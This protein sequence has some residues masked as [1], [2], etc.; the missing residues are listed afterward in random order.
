M[1][2]YACGNPRRL[3][4][5]AQA[6][7]ANAIEF[8]EVR[9]SDEP[10]EA[11]KQR[12]LLVHLVLPVPAGLTAS[13]IV[14]DGGERIPQVGVEWAVGADTLPAAD[15]AALLPG[16][17]HLDRVLVVRTEERG[18]F[19]RYRFALVR[20]GTDDPA[21]GFDPPLSH[22]SFS[23]KVECPND[24]DCAQPCTCAP[25]IHH[26][27]TIDYLAKDYQGFRRI[28]L[29]RMAV[30]SPDWTER[31]SAD[32]GITLIE[33][34]AYLADELSY[35]QDAVATEAYLNT[36][37]SRISLRRHARL[38]DYR[39]HDG[40]NARV[41][42]RIQLD[43]SQPSLPLAAGTPLLTRVA[44]LPPR[45]DPG[46]LDEQAARAAKPVVFET[47]EDAV[48][49]GDLGTLRFWTWGRLDASL[50]AGA[51]CA[52]LRGAHP[53]LRPGEVLMLVE[54]ASPRDREADPDPLRRWPVRL[55][56][57]T[58]AEDPAG[59][60][61]PDGV[62]DVTEIRWHPDDALPW[63]LCLAVDGVETAQAW[64]N[65]VLAD[66]G[67]AA[68]AVPL[69]VVPESHLARAET[70]CDTDPELIPVRFRP[71][72]PLQS[73]TRAVA[74]PRE[75]LL[76]VP[77]TPE[78]AGELAA[79]AVGDAFQA[80]FAALDVTVPDGTTI[81]GG[82]GLHAV[83]VGDAAWTIRSTGTGTL[84]LLAP[85]GPA[86]DAL[87][88][89]PRD[90]RP[91][92]TVHGVESDGTYPWTVLP[93][94]LGSSGDERAFVVEAEADGTAFLRFGDGEY[95]AAPQAG[96]RFSVEGRIGNG[97]QGNI[98]RE[99]LAHIVVAGQEILSV[100]NP[101]AASGGTDPETSD[102][103]RRD[104]PATLAVQE[105]AVTASDYEAMAL[106]TRSVARAAA[107]FRW[108]G[109]WHTVFVTA[110][111]AGGGPVDA[112]FETRLRGDL[113]RY[114]MAGS[115]LEVDA[116]RFVPLEIA[117]H[118]C[119]APGHRRAD[120]TAAARD[121]LSNRVLADGTLG[122]FHP[123][124]YTFGQSVQLSDLLVALH[125][126]TGVESV[127]TTKFQRQHEPGTTGLDDGLLPMGRLEVARLDNDPSFPEHGVL[128]LTCGGGL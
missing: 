66:H 41:W 63:S 37:R 70:T 19:S 9:H 28:M 45:I 17:T 42:A 114:R 65:V 23:F 43:P 18:D 127:D 110:D 14:V 38:V 125:A 105:R 4:A 49:H 1:A 97:R 126:I 52:T 116:P 36:A 101:L 34:L 11:L 61:F 6:G 85:P 68:A 77:R 72:L 120:V 3:L 12:T 25:D 29:E 39:V 27:P 98:G 111:R 50:P 31:S 40:C 74:A 2:R 73:V 87:V 13:W 121:V 10:D 93:D 48:L 30:L 86:V 99:T 58:V 67:A 26:P 94:L 91:V 124:R 81:L 109:S 44:D 21:P 107:T 100:S 46:S 51:T 35:R 108:T 119:V 128:E 53:A 5:I 79:G 32:V 96:T 118:V 76:E 90:A 104:A 33:L 22:V 7:T 112:P 95:A 80:V 117:L 123:D 88:P 75:P 89:A 83:G 20:P 64:G 54:S 103:I 47:V 56:S 57:V 84:Q 8:L 92:V 106:R 69:G 24:L 55:V 16:V 60:L 122:L 59:A 102:E 71:T 78:L 15:A 82:R 62:T 115:D 113:E